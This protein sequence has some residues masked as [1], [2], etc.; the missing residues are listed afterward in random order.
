MSDLILPPESD[1]GCIEYKLKLSDLNDFEIQKKMSQLQYRM[2]E[3]NGEAIYYLGVKDN[4]TIIGLEE[5]EHE[6]SVNNLKLIA[7]KI[8]ATIINVNIVVLK[9]SNKYSEFIIRE[10]AEDTYLDLKIG[11]VG[12]VDSGKSTLVGVLTK[13]VFDNGRGSA[14]SMVFNFKHE[15]DTGRTSSIGHQI[16]GFDINGEIINCKKN[17]LPLKWGDITK[18]AT[19]IVTFYDL[20]GHEKYLRT[21]IYGLSSSYPDYC[22]VIAGGNL[23]ISHMT[24]EHIGLCLALKIP[25]IVVITKIDIAP[26][27]I[28]KETVRRINQMC[29]KGARKIP[30]NIKTKDDILTVSKNIKSDTI[31]PILQVSSV[32]HENMDLLKLLLNILPIRNDYSQFVKLPIELLVDSHFYITGHGTVVSGLLRSGTIKINDNVFIGPSLIGEYLP[33]KVKS[34]HIKHS[35]VKEAKAGSYICIAL[36]NIQRKII[37]KGMVVIGDTTEKKL[38]KEF[39]AKINILQSHSTT[40]KIGYEP[41]IHI[42]QVR[43][44]AKI[45]KIEKINNSDDNQV[46]RTGDRAFIKLKFNKCAE[47]IKTD[48]HLVFR[49]GKVKA[50]GIIIPDRDIET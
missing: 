25:F 5:K 2:N 38:V 17:G 36:K 26:P 41:Y 9:N 14:R 7:S 27:D 48:M 35:D 19:K 20:A 28:L 10:F 33:T 45:L 18:E 34:I 6:E 37:R 47:Y 31:V 49:D 11:V 8:N 46:L 3:G 39:W 42:A 13:G 40:I 15:I 24:R 4:G 43:Q 29:K 22:L 21:T 44:I 50:F 1:D 16:A 32:S 30:Y 23:G 12:N